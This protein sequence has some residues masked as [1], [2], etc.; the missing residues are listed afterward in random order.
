MIRAL[1]AEPER[2]LATVLVGTNLATTMA[3]QAGVILS[4]LALPGQEGLQRLVNTALVTT[5]VLVFCEILPKTICH[6]RANS[7]ALRCA[8]P[9]RQSS[10]LL[11]PIVAVV[12]AVTKRVTVRHEEEGAAAETRITRDELQLL[13][14]MGGAEDQLRSDQLQMIRNV[15]GAET[16]TIDRIMV[17]LVNLAALPHDATTA[18]LFDLVTET[19]YSRIPVYEDRIDNIVGYVTIRE[20]LFGAADA[21]DAGTA[22]GAPGADRIVPFV[23]RDVGYEPGTRQVLSLLHQLRT[24]GHP[25]AIVVDEYGGVI[26]LVTTE[27]L[28]EEILGDIRDERDEDI[29][30]YIRRIS[31]GVYDCDGRAEVL[32][33][34]RLCGAEIPTGNYETIAGYVLSLSQRIPRQGE[35]VET[36]RLRITVLAS[37]ARRIRRVRMQLKP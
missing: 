16:R 8:G 3:G 24:S 15:L 12:T 33:V 30:A 37:D 17:P 19:G 10:R 2:L 18:Q 25:L 9:L 20:V 32:A 5:L 4:T 1:L 13:A 36:D 22:A 7:L 23:R 29:H 6:A 31:A 11:Y 28:V 34:N 35:L 27:D 14:S 26:G 21:S